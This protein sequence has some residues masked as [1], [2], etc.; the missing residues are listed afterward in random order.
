MEKAQMV[1]PFSKK[2][3]IECA[4]FRGRHYYLCSAPR[5]PGEK[6]IWSTTKW[7]KV[8]SLKRNSQAEKL[9]ILKL[10][11]KCLTNVEDCM[12]RR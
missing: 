8:E 7:F 1:C 5:S 10:S 12:E 4:V 2:S 11:S 3:C 6:S 9:P